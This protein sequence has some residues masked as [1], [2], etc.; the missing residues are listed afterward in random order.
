MPVGL[1]PSSAAALAKWRAE[2]LFLAVAWL[3]NALSV[4]HCDEREL[5]LTHYCAQGNQARLKATDANGDRIV[6]AFLDA[7]N[8]APDQGVMVALTVALQGDAFDQESVYR[9]PTGDP[10][11]TRLHFVRAEPPA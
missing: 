8:V 5:M 6:F 9:T 2:A 3:G 7:T 1:A 11:T 10:D 4:Y